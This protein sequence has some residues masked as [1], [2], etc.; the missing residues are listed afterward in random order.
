MARIDYIQWKDRWY[1]KW[2][3]RID[4]VW[5][6]HTPLFNIEDWMFMYLDGG[7]IFDIQFGSAKL[8]GVSITSKNPFKITFT[9][10]K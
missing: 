8:G 1:A 9:S 7:L 2:K 5:Y 4:I 10:D 3:D 6:P